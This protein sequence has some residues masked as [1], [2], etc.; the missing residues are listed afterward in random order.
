MET[1]H[2]SFTLERGDDFDEGMETPNK[3]R[4]S[5]KTSDDHKPK[6]RKKT[7]VSVSHTPGYLTTL[8]HTTL[9]KH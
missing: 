4:F 2:G 1:D 5:L 7:T 6:M 8:T 9:L 3:K